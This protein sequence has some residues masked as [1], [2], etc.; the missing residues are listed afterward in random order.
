MRVR[1]Y[2]CIEPIDAKLS[3]LRH[4]KVSRQAICTIYQ[5]VWESEFKNMLNVGRIWLKFKNEENP[6][7]IPLRDKRCHQKIDVGDIIRIDNEFYMV[8]Q[9]GGRHIQ[10][11][12]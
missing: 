8:D 5:L 6:F 10:V 11:V 12:D 4:N 9:V 7:G 3:I 1:V 2:F